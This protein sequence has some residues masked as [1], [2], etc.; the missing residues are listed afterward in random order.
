MSLQLEIDDAAREVV[1]RV[2]GLDSVWALAPA[3]MAGRTGGTCGPAR[4][5]AG[6]CSGAR[7]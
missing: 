3:Q 6:R 5:A 4:V 1:V 2:G 7:P